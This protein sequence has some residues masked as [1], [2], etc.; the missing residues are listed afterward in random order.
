MSFLNVRKERGEE[1]GGGQL[2]VMA[3]YPETDTWREKE[4][5]MCPVK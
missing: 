3:N 1:R 5:Q 4:R 2:T